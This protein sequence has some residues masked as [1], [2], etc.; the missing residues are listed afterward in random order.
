MAVKLNIP[1]SWNE[2]NQNQFEKIALLFTT[3][4]PSLVRD[5][6]LFKILVNAKWWQFILKGKFAYFLKQVPYSEWKQHIEFLIKEN[7]RTV[8]EPI[9]KVKNKTYYAPMDRIQ[10]LTADEFAVADDLHIRYRETQNIEFLQYLFHVLYQE[11]EDR[12]LFVK[13]HLPKLINK[14][15]PV[16]TLIATELVYFGSKNHMVSKFKKAFPKSSKKSNGTRTGFGKVI[17]KMAKDD[18]SKAPII[19]QTNIY[20]FLTQFQDDIEAIQ[21][22]KK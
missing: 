15:I 8:F 10:N 21:K 22:A 13:N 1:A 3:A 14:N 2:L 20:E 18:L 19:K 11:Q 7:N 16:K 12:V 5:I 6:R 4:E 9:I 17:Q